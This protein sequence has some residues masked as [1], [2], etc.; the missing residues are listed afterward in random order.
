MAGDSSGLYTL[1]PR[2]RWGNIAPRSGKAVDIGPGY[3]FHR[4][5]PLDIIEI[6]VEL[7]ITDY[8]AEAVNLAIERF[9]NRVELLQREQV[10]R[11]ILGGAP[12]SAQLGRARI[13]SLLDEAEQKTGIPCDA[14][15]EAVIS[16]MQ[17]LGLTRLAIGSCW[18]KELNSLVSAYL[19][20]GGIETSAPPTV[21]SGLRRPR[22]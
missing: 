1:V 4:L 5:V 11:I 9:W 16:S 2:F 22:R 6:K 12:V 13:R 7:G 20:A 19:Q 14:P 21:G 17:Y 8:T 18:S 3:E 10:D 15:L